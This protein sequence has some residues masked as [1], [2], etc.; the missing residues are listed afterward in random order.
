MVDGGDQPEQGPDRSGAAEVDLNGRI[1]SRFG[2]FGNQ[3][4]QFRLAH[5]VTVAPDG[6]IFVVDAWRQRVQRFVRQVRCFAKCRQKGWQQNVD[7]RN[8]TG[9]RQN[10]YFASFQ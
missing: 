1:L 3:D 10:P 6:S 8:E 7:F 5:D 4:G 9:R 2:R